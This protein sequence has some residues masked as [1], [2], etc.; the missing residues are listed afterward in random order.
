[1]K[2]QPTYENCIE[3]V[4]HLLEIIEEMNKSNYE[5]TEDDAVKVFCKSNTKKIWELGLTKLEIY[6]SGQKLKFGKAKG[7]VKLELWTS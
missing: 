3:D 5:I 6:K 2:E 4:F 7:Y 1:M